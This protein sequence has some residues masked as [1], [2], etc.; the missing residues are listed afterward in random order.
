[1]C[2]L[3]KKL[4]KWFFL[5]LGVHLKV[6][7]TTISKGF[8]VCFFKEERCARIIANRLPV[9]SCIKL[10][11]VSLVLHG[12]STNL[13][14]THVLGTTKSYQGPT[15]EWIFGRA[16]LPPTLTFV[17][18]NIVASRNGTLHSLLSC[19]PVPDLL[20]SST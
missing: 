17:D 11:F 2:S 15:N 16:R 14:T 9:F 7:N 6:F 10:L 18:V 1:M 3:L 5:F 13:L 20:P 19:S 12:L 4:P 8:L